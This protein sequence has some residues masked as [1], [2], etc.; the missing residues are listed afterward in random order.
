M[1]RQ[2]KGGS[3]NIAFGDR[4]FVL[5][6]ANNTADGSR[7]IKIQ[8]RQFYRDKSNRKISESGRYRDPSF[9]SR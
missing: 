7:L 2:S 6:G 3:N 4:S 8:E 5:N 9:H 1:Y